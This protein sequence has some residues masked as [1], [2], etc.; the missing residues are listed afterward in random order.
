MSDFFMAE[1]ESGVCYRKFKY[2]NGM[3]D[4]IWAVSFVYME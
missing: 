1:S 4:P 3:D 2:K